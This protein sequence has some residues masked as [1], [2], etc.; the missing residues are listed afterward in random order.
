MEIKSS[1]VR[2]RYK[3]SDK[4]T[5]HYRLIDTATKSNLPKTNASLYITYTAL[6]I[7]R[8]GLL[9]NINQI[10][11]LNTNI[12]TKKTAEMLFSLRNSIKDIC[13]NNLLIK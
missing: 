12:T 8:I 11:V 4:I 6:K 5:H 3:K 10:L 13:F 7:R 1:L 2:V 9:I